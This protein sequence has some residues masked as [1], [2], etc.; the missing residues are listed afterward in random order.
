MKTLIQVHLQIINFH[1]PS[2]EKDKNFTIVANFEIKIKE[3]KNI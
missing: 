3:P 1:N 2:K